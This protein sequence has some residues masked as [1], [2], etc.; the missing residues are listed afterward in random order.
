M[1]LLISQK[2]QST[3]I[4]KACPPP[5]ATVAVLS[6]G[7]HMTDIQVRGNKQRSCRGQW[8]VSYRQLS[9]SV[10]VC[11]TERVQMIEEGLNRKLNPFPSRETIV[12]SFPLKHT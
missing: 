10:C 8:G 6:V 2:A 11:V 4:K 5:D 12:G 9:C 7:C 3:S 1:S